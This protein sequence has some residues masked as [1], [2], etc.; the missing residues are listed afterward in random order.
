MLKR[1]F[2]VVSLVLC[3][4]VLAGCNNRNNVKYNAVLYDNAVDWIDETFA[5]NNLVRGAYYED[6]QGEPEPEIPLPYSRYFIVKSETEF[7]EIFKEDS[8]D[9]DFETQ[10]VIVY[11][12][13]IEYRNPAEL[14]SVSLD[15]ETLKI[16]YGIELI[17]HTGSACQPFQRWFVIKMNK[18][19]ISSVTFSEQ[20][21]Y[22]N[23]F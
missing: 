6:I 9:V 15:G 18:L 4:G 20:Y 7:N 21:V 5:S 3:L 22:V 13:R 10:M 16:T 1:L 12:L 14:R 19:D 2:C 8:L 17:P 11:T 23:N